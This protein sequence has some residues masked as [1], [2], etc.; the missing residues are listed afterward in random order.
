MGMHMQFISRCRKRPCLKIIIFDLL[1]GETKKIKITSDKP[2]KAE[3]I[4]ITCI[5]QSRKV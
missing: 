5:N 3:A 1:P 4:K 2:L